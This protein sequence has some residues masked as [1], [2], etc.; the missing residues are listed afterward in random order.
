MRA[1]LDETRR[2]GYVEGSIANLGQEDFLYSRIG[3]E[4]TDDA[5]AFGLGRWTVNEQ[6]AEGPRIE[7]KREDIV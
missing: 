1:D 6:L 4:V 2:F 5:H 3:F 7:L